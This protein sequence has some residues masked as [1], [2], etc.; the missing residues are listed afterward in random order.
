[1]LV[2]FL[3]RFIGLPKLF[4]SHNCFNQYMLNF[5]LFLW[6][7]IHL[8]SWSLMLLNCSEARSNPCSCIL[9]NFYAN[10]AIS[11]DPKVI[12]RQNLKTV[13]SWTQYNQSPCRNLI[14]MNLNPVFNYHLSGLKQ[15]RRL[16]ELSRVELF[17]QFETC[18]RHTTLW[19]LMLAKHV[20][21]PSDNASQVWVIS[22]KENE[23]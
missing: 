23:S 16:L 19:E 2:S 4:K 10:Y 21:L 7:K 12:N 11:N 13:L 3:C 15:T 17:L 1:M 18:L 20:K 8:R 9:E 22:G 14:V 6:I 5:C